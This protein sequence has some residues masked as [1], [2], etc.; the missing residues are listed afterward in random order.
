MTF[1]PDRN[2]DL[3]ITGTL[4]P[5]SGDALKKAVEHEAQKILKA[6]IDAQDQDVLPV[7]KRRMIGLMRLVS[8]G[9]VRQDGT[10]PFP[11]VNIVM[12]QKVAEALLED[13]AN[14]TDT[15]SELLD[16]FDIDRRC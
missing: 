11:L 15:A 16:P 6:Q 9:F 3:H 8:R 14:D 2:G 13:L 12:S 5:I 4:D 7:R 10:V 1:R